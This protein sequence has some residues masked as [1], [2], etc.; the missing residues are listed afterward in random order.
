MGDEGK[1]VG[2]LWLCGDPQLTRELLGDV[3]SVLDIRISR[4]DG[5]VQ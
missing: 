4:F 5:L 1:A 3:E 2:L